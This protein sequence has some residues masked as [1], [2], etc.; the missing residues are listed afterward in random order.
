MAKIHD[1]N[2]LQLCTPKNPFLPRAFLNDWSHMLLKAVRVG[3]SVGEKILSN[4]IDVN[5]Q[6]NI[7]ENK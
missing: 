4:E 1:R 2:L 6:Y 7:Q 3:T 5:V